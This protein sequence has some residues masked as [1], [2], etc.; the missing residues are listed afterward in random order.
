MNAVPAALASLLLV[1][2]LAQADAQT[3]YRCGPDGREYSQAP[4]PAGREV[5]VSDARSAGQ[6]Q[7]AAAVV[8]DQNR[9]ADQLAAERQARERAT[10]TTG[11]AANAV[12]EAVSSAVAAQICCIRILS[13]SNVNV[14]TRNIDCTIDEVKVLLCSKH[15]SS[16]IYYSCRVQN[17]SISIEQNSLHRVPSI[18]CGNWEIV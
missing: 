14:S 15:T 4:C 18:V 17:H 8:K 16:N 9:L 2:G 10:P 5:D 13:E 3:V 11:P 1:L 12:I 6:R 7:A